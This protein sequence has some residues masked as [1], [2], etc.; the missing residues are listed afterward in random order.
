MNTTNTFKRLQASSLLMSLLAALLYT[1]NVAANDK[2]VAGKIDPD[3]LTF[4]ESKKIFNDEE[5]VD[6][7]FE[8]KRKVLIANYRV[9]FMI[10]AS[11]A[12]T[13][14]GEKT[15]TSNFSGQDRVTFY[16]QHPDA[17][18]SA[19]ATVEYDDALLQEIT[20]EGYADLQARLTA[21]GREIVTM[22][23]IKDKEGYKKLEI[24]KPD[25]KGQYVSEDNNGGVADVNYIA[26]KPASIP[27][28]FGMANPLDEGGAL[29]KAG[30]ALSMKNMGAF[31]QLA[32]D[33]DAVIIDLTFRVRPAFVMGLRS[34]MFRAAAVKA[35]P[36]LAVLPEAI[37]VQTYKNTWVGNVPS[38]LGALRVKTPAYGAYEETKDS[39]FNYGY[40][41]GNFKV[42]NNE[43][44]T[45]FFTPSYEKTTTVEISPNRAKFKETVLHALKTANA[46]L[47]LWA[48]EN[49]AD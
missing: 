37:L 15:Q 33:A 22:E 34:K 27:M 41:Y 9:G 16:I 49:P 23:D 17:H 29:S 40:D 13:E 10:S 30:S 24:A 18:L 2:G 5:N 39:P 47:A 12:V 35:D 7:A 25:E 20:E 38:E 26:K 42:N 36:Y 28:W 48:K 8:E 44:D 3:K 21:V 31:K 45:S 43:V 4:K 32:V 46:T 19:N 11:A 1:S 6:D 14:E